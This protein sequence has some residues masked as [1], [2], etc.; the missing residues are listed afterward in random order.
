MQTNAHL[1]EWSLQRRRFFAIS[2]RSMHL[3]ARGRGVFAVAAVAATVFVAARGRAQD[4]G[5]SI[6]GSG[7][8]IVPAPSASTS[9]PV[10]V[11]PKVKVYVEPVYPAARLAKGERAEVVVSLVIDATGKVTDAKIVASAGDDFDASALE[12]AKKLVFEPATADGK[13]I[14]SKIGKYRF[15]FDFKEVP[16][17][18]GTGAA[19][20]AGSATVTAQGPVLVLAGKLRTPVED[21]IPGASVL[22]MSTTGATYSTV[23]DAA[24]AFSFRDLPDGKYQLRVEVSGFLPFVAE[25]T[26]KRGTVTEVVYRPTLAGEGVDILVTGEKPP[27]EVVKRQLEQ[28][29]ITR[30]PGTNGDA[31]RAIQNMPGV[32]R[33][34]GFAGLLIIRG[35]S[36]FDT[37]VFVDG[38]LIPLA[39]HFGGLSSVVPSELLEKIDFYPGNFGPEYGRVMGGIVDVGIRS[40]HKTEYHG[41]LQFDLLDGRIVAEG[42]I[43]TKTRFA[44]AGRRSWVDVWLKPVLEKTGTGVSTAP[45]YY[46]YQV[47]LERDLTA[48]TTGR[49]LFLGSDDKLAIT[50]NSPAASDPTLGGDIS[51]HTGFWRLQARTDTRVTKD[52]RWLNTLAYGTDKIDFAVGDYF[53]KLTGHPLTFRSD[54][55]TKVSNEAQLVVGI[56]TLWSSYDVAFKFPPP[57]VPGEAAGPFFARPASELQGTGSLYRPAA[58]ALLDLSPVKALHLIPALRVDYAKDTGKWNLSPRFVARYDLV[59]GF[60]RTTVKGAAGIFYQPPQPQE[61]IPP[62]G[63]TGLKSNRATHYDLGVEQEFTRQLEVSVDGFFKDLQDLVVRQNINTTANGV[64]YSNVGSGRVYGVEVLLRYKPDDVFFGWIAYTLSK[65]ERRDAPDQ[66]LHNFQ[67]DQ[68]HIFT[69]LGSFRLGR[70][71]ELGGRF[72]YVTGSM[73]T[74]N[75]GGVSDFDAGAYAPVPTYP[76]FGGRLPAFHQADIRIDKVWK[77]SSWQ[78]SAYLDVQNVYVRRNP[79]GITYNY[80]YSQHDVISGIPILPILGVRG[81]L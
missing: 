53:F 49:L 13:P 79:E 5:T 40:P 66:P 48:S 69:I 77:F 44:I 76:P 10:M 36:P 71:W 15:K 21:P 58:Y 8:K 74:P 6:G 9:G 46:D 45:V 43:D 73:Y 54:V 11:P 38:T 30:I 33:P 64:V 42:P 12:A 7:A 31:L 25:E 35:S 14:A 4:D 63:T 80:N 37:N 56:D 51:A 18:S 16:T 55:R 23:T 1:R 41:L 20:G 22:A 34:P 68:T 67:Y 24:G 81:Q 32:A 59:A 29:E 39:Y 47:M 70:G 61:S 28:R 62:F 27:R 57:P 75:Q 72:R 19:T 78:I 3:R 2:S 26:I 17:G 65:S 52:I 60:P 50:L